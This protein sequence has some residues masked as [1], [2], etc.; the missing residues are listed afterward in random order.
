[1][2]FRARY[3]QTPAPSV[4]W[5][6]FPHKRR[7]PDRR[8]SRPLATRRHRTGESRPA[9]TQLGVGGGGWRFFTR[10]C[11]LAILLQEILQ[12]GAALISW[13]NNWQ[14]LEK[15]QVWI[16][17]IV[18]QKRV[19]HRKCKRSLKHLRL[20]TNSISDVPKNGYNYGELPTAQSD[21]KLYKFY[22]NGVIIFQMKTY[23]TITRQ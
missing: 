8:R 1:M 17:T 10:I 16:Y 19:Q 9:L 2:C 18:L 23:R 22:S 11:A 13:Q 21:W 3:I 15:S 12:F 7:P 4:T 5:L 14:I 20:L 6:E